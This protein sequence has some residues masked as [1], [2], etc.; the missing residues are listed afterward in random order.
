MNE[1]K[2]VAWMWR[3]PKYCAEPGWHVSKKRPADA[4]D[5]KSESYEDYPLYAIPGTHRVVSV[6]TLREAVYALEPMCR[7]ESLP[8]MLAS[9]SLLAI[10]DNKGATK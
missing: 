1:L 9:R 10:I 6:E 8:A 7:Q 3:C 4:N 2:P 5:P